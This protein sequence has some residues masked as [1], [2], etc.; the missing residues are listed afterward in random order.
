MNIRVFETKEE[1]S[2]AAAKAVATLIQHNPS[3]TLGL[4]TGAT[5]VLLYQYLL[6]LKPV[7]NDIQ[8]FNLDEYIGVAPSHPAS[9]YHY[10]DVHYVTP[11]QLSAAQVHRPSG[12]L[13]PLEALQAYR[14][15]LRNATIDLQLLGIGTNGHIG[16]NEPGC[17]FNDDVHIE[18]LSQSTKQANQAAFGSVELVPDLAITMGIKT[19]LSAKRIVLLAFGD[20]KA[21]AVA[22]MVDGP[23]TNALPASVLQQHPNVEIYLDKAAASQLT[24]I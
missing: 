10:M 15:A 8:S 21:E 22:Q 17:D 16:F 1:A 24:K 13:P 2:L 5:P 3:A 11:F 18:T 23:L 20:A 6:A 12:E 7:M 9:F 4:A 14:D 19:I